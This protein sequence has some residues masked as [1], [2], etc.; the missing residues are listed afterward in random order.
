M[1]SPAHPSDIMEEVLKALHE[2]E[3]SWKKIG[4]YSVRYN[5][6]QDTAGSFCKLRT[7][8]LM[9]YSSSSRPC[10]SGILWH[11]LNFGFMTSLN[12]KALLLIVDIKS[13][14]IKSIAPA[15][16]LTKDI[17]KEGDVR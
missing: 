3:I 14:S 5:N 13:A 17:Y 6:L 11:V 12:V 4:P 2:L 10:P 15:L 8:F 16:T 7:C 9:K 1:Q